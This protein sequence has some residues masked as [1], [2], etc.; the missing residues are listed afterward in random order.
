MLLKKRLFSMRSDG[1]ARGSQ[2]RQQR[3]PNRSDVAL[4]A[5]FGHEASPRLQRPVHALKNSILITH[6]V[7]RRIGKDGVEFLVEGQ[8][9]PLL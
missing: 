6:P 3:Y 7:Q 2:H 5:T 1:I 8:R 9:F 4:A